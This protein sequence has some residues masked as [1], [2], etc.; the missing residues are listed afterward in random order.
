MDIGNTIS[1][2]H[3]AVS[4]SYHSESVGERLAI[5]NCFEYFWGEPEFSDLNA[6]WDII[7]E[8]V[9]DLD[10][11]VPLAHF[12]E[13]AGLF[14]IRSVKTALVDGV[15]YFR[16]TLS[17]EDILIG[18]DAGR[19]TITVF[20]QRE[21]HDHSYIRNLVR[22]PFAARYIKLGYVAM[23]AA[24]CSINGQGILFPG[25]KGAGKSTLLIHLLESGARFIANDAVLCGVERNVVE[26][27]TYPQCVRLSEETV[28]NSTL[29]STGIGEAKSAAFIR[30]K[31]EILP[32]VFDNIYGKP[33]L[34]KRAPL[35]LVVVPQIDTS[36]RDFEIEIGQTPFNSDTLKETLF[37]PSH[38]YT[39]SPLFEELNEPTAELNNFARVS[40]YIPDIRWCVVKYGILDFVTQ[41]ELYRQI[42]DMLNE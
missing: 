5:K 9:S 18:F 27:V 1:V 26:L 2:N 16:H 37:F 11:I 6:S 14:K 4:V 41:R 36:R 13:S 31:Q 21:L 23:H 28:K 19:N 12:S 17:G 24:A 38:E 15:A 40:K 20:H 32:E 25:N 30:G 8:I 34:Q 29:L 3:L 39:W 7:S 22:E 35:R 33:S 10:Q 42:S